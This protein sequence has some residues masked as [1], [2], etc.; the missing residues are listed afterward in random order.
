M[1]NT[2]STQY[3]LTMLSMLLPPVLIRSK[4]LPRFFLFPHIR[5]NSTQIKTTKIESTETSISTS[6]SSTRIFWKYTDQYTSTKN[7]VVLRYTNNL[8]KRRLVNIN[9]LRP[10]IAMDLEW[11]IWGPINVCLIQLCDE[12]SILLI[13]LALMRGISMTSGYLF[14]E[15]STGVETSFGR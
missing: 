3:I 15:F 12:H 7:R 13:H 5:S 4:T 2:L 8:K 1:N 6:T 11:R 9:V 10:V 14:R